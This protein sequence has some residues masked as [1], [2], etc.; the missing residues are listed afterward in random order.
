MPRRNVRAVLLV[1]A[2][3]LIFWRTSLNAKPRD[4]MMELYGTFVDAVEQVE[5]NY[6]RP[7]NRKELLES[8]LK[9]MLQN[10]DEHS[11]YLSESDFK[12]FQKDL[13][14]SFS[15]IGVSVTIDTDS[16]RLKILAPLVGG[17][18]YAAGVMAGDIVLDID[19]NST[20]GWTR[21]KAVEALTGRVG[22]PVK[23]T[24]MHPGAEK[25]ESLSMNRA[26]IELPSILGDIRKADDSWDFFIDK[27]SKIAYIRLNGF[28]GDTDEDLKK[29]LEELKEQGMK[30]LV[31]DLRNNP[32]GRLDSAVE[33]CD[34]FVEEGKIVSTKGRNTRTTTHPATKGGLFDAADGKGSEVLPMAVLI[35]GNSASASEV[36]SACLQDHSRA[37]IVGRRSYGK[38][39]V[40]HIIQLDE[41]DSAL[42][43][44]VASY[45]RPSGKNIHRDP[46]RSKDTDEWGVTPDA[47]YDVKLT[48]EEFEDWYIA[49]RDRDL[50]SSHNPARPKKDKDGK[51][52]A[53]KPFVDKQLEKALEF[54]RGEIKAA[55]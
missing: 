31:L 46:K 21:D 33:I 36:V 6:V 40:Q 42:K 51:G 24:V 15:G 17:P 7:V 28:Y 38:G 27:E 50:I 26:I 10:L 45:W 18:A 13:G 54:V 30:G 22:T 35:N 43:I 12:Q 19:G 11:T 32:G 8:A 34:M 14:E 48:P 39:S 44:T 37:K 5:A 3:S 52:D 4:E 9:G 47:G 20:E 25:T 49:R 1:V 16:N 41:G 23:M 2:I 55:K 53:P 29:V